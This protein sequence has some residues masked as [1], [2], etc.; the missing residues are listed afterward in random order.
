MTEPHWIKAARSSSTNACVELAV[1]DGQL[2]LRN[3]RAPEV[4]LRFTRHEV[5][6][7]LDGLRGGEFDE[8]LTQL[9]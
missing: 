8:I 3:S 4:V 1:I 7:F 2:A 5:G 9:S 6:A